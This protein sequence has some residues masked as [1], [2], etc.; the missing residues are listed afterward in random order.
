MTFRKF[1]IPA[2]SNDIVTSSTYTCRK[3]SPSFVDRYKYTSWRS[4]EVRGG[5]E[6]DSAQGVLL[7]PFPFH[8]PFPSYCEAAQARRYFGSDVCLC[9]SIFDAAFW[10]C[11]GGHVISTCVTYKIHCVPTSELIISINSYIENEINPYD[12][13]TGAESNPETWYITCLCFKQCA[14]CNIITV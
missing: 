4:A 7:P 9:I 1:A 11:V 10:T 8:F 6:S 3:I 2:W 12:I 5:R 13:V 14:K